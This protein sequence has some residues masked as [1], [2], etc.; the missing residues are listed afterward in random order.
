[1]TLITLRFSELGHNLPRE[2]DEVLTDLW[3][4]LDFHMLHVWNIYLQNWVILFGPR[5]INIP[6]SEHIMANYNDL[7][8]TSLESLVNK[9]CH[10]LL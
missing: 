9:G 2:L 10:S 3:M 1:M 6:Y 5:L 7:T 8:T 4:I